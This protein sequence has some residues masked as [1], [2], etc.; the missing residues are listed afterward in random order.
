MKNNKINRTWLGITVLFLI[1]IF[2]QC[3]SKL[4]GLVAD[5]FNYSTIDDYNIFAWITVHHIVQMLLALLVIIIL[6]KKYSIDFGFHF[7]NKSLGIK[8]IITFFIAIFIYTVISYAIGYFNNQI[9]QYRYPLNLKNVLGSLGFQ[10]FLSGPSEE[11]LFRALPIS[12]ITYW[13]SSG[14]EIK[15]AKWNISSATIIS[16]IFFSVAHIRWTVYPFSLSMDYFQLIYAL[17]LGI[18]YGNAYQKS[19][20]IVYPMILHSMSNVIMVGFGFL[21]EYLGN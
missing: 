5:S 10:L 4:G 16:A 12:I 11:I 9:P 8:Y 19:G 20:S 21:F 14:K 3:A 15:I 7:G 2:Q 17:I 13:V 18:I 6:S 1:F